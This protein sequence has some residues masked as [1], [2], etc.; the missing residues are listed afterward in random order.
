MTKENNIAMQK[1]SLKLC[2]IQLHDMKPKDPA[3]IRRYTVKHHIITLT[4]KK[5]SS[6]AFK[7]HQKPRKSTAL[8]EVGALFLLLSSCFSPSLSK[9]PIKILL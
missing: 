4:V 8:A 6:V 2:E 7:H 5:S 1:C 9:P 3:C